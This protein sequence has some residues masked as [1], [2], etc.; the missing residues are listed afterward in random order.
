MALAVYP[1]MKST[2]SSGRSSRRRRASCGPLMFGI[3]TSVTS[4]SNFRPGV[5]AIARASAAVRAVMT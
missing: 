4:T 3:M 2:L 5:E 1:D